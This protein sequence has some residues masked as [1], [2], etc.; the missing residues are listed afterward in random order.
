M[1]KRVSSTLQFVW[2]VDWRVGEA[3]SC[4][5]SATPPLPAICICS[6]CTDKCTNVSSAVCVTVCT[7]VT[8]SCSQSACA[9]VCFCL[10]VQSGG[11]NR[12]SPAAS[13]ACFGPQLSQW[14]RAR[15]H[16][17]PPVCVCTLW[18]APVCVCVCVCCSV[19]LHVKIKSFCNRKNQ[20]CSFLC[21]R[22]AEEVSCCSGGGF[23]HPSSR[24]QKPGLHMCLYNSLPDKYT[25]NIEVYRCEIVN[26]VSLLIYRLKIS[27]TPQI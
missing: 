18:P 8:D 25:S 14:T 17:W 3:G 23:G 9:C 11:L 22:A 5:W 27:M 10:C 12:H 7:W 2:N 26:K 15:R 13:N 20:V 6:A 24:P 19:Q 16:A 4:S 21:Q 1:C